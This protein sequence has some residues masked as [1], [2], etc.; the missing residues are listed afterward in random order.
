[1]K[2]AGGLLKKE[3]LTVYV[4]PKVKQGM[5]FAA[6]MENTN[7]SDLVERLLVEYLRTIEGIGDLVEKGK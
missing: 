2:W 7:L 6:V 3:Q 5:K 4:H 1:M